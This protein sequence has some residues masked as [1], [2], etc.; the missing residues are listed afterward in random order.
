M[1]AE[2]DP[3]GNDLAARF[4][5]FPQVGMTSL[6]LAHRHRDQAE[7][8]FD[9]HLQSLPGGLE[10]LVGPVSPDASSSLDRELTAV[11]AGIFPKSVD[12]LVDCGRVLGGRVGQQELLQSADRVLVVSRSEIADL[13]HARWTLDLVRD[14]ARDAPVSLVLVGSNRFSSAEIEQALQAPP[15]GVIPLDADSAAMVCGAPGRAKRFARGALVGAA[16]ELVG[17]LS[18]P[19]KRSKANFGG[20][21]TAEYPHSLAGPALQ[22]VAPSGTSNGDSS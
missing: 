11:G 20:E 2:C 22:E 16:R 13:A 1:L 9:T 17:R 14:L 21:R 8:S 3:S 5:L 7:P 10:V 15:F 6:V 18:P 4:G 12:V 19:I